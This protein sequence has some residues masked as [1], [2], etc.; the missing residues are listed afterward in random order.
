MTS[1]APRPDFDPDADEGPVGPMTFEEYLAFEE[2]SEVRHEFVDGYAVAMS[3]VTNAHD[4]IA[5]NVQGHLWLRTRGSRCRAHTS[6]FKL[7]TPNGRAYYPDVMVSCGPT[8]PG[9]AL[10]RDDACLAVEVLSPSTG[11]TDHTDKR[12]SYTA[13][14]TLGAYLIVESTWRAVHRHW[15]DADGVWQYE[16]IAGAGGVVPLPCPAGEAL[17]LD[18][19]YEGLDLPPGPPSP[20]RLRR[21]READPAGAYAAATAGRV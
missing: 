11:R 6:D 20:A 4:L 12:E 1:P 21:V 5:A 3:G 8:L 15:R 10:Y 17:T 9:D 14:P 18:E 13:I 2:A 7:R 16:V 19:I